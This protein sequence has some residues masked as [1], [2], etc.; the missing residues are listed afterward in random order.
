MSDKTPEQAF[1]EALASFQAE[2]W[3]AVAAAPGYEV[4]SLGRVRSLDRS[5]VRGGHLMRRR[6]QLLALKPHGTDG[7]YRQVYLGR[8][9]YRLVHHLVLETFVG[10]RPEGAD[11]CHNNGDPADNRA[12][13]LRW[14][15]RAG[16]IRDQLQHGT[17]PT[18]SR[19]RCPR[20]HELR[21][22]NLTPSM[23]PYRQ[24]LACN[25][26]RARMK[27]YAK[28]AQPADFEQVAAAYYE[29]IMGEAA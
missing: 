25:R 24:C 18:A 28:Q 21:L 5:V 16:N 26:A 2:E 13:N 12:S 15:S 29:Q 7:K 27:V 6:G 23:L 14:D 20:G 22:P 1:A 11:G 8:R 3:R 4:S 9:Q 10:A 19:T 17:H